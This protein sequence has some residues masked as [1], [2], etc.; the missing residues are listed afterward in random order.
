MILD[1]T[2]AQT[3]SFANPGAATSRFHNVDITNAAGVTFTSSVYVT[4]Q[5]TLVPGSVLNQSGSL[6]SFYT[7]H[8]PVLAEDATYNVVN[9]QVQGDIV[10]TT[11]VV[12][13]QPD[14]HLIINA[15]KSLVVNGQQLR[16]GGN[17]TVTISNTTADGL[18]MTDPADELII[19]GDAV[20]TTVVNHGL[21]N[22]TGNFTAGV[23]RLRGDYT[24]IQS[25]GVGSQT[26]FV[27][28]GTKVI[29]D[30]TGTQTVSFANPGT[31]VSRFHDVGIENTSL[32]SVIFIS[33]VVATGQLI[34]PSNTTS[35]IV[36]NGHAFSVTG[37]D[38]DRLILDNVAFTV[39]G[40]PI[41]RFDHVTFQNYASTTTQFT[42]N[43]TDLNAAFAGL[44]FLVEPTSGKYLV[45][46]D[47]D[48]GIPATVTL[49]NAQPT[50]G[51]AFT[52]ASGGFI[53]NWT[54]QL[55]A[56]DDFDN[57]LED[58]PVIINV[59]DNDMNPDEGILTITGVTQGAGGTVTIDPGD[60][61]ITYTPIFDFHGADTFT[62]TM[63]DG[64]DTDTAG[65]MVTVVPDEEPVITA[66]PSPMDF[67][68]VTVGGHAEQTLYVR[69]E[70]PGHLIVTDI[71]DPFFVVTDTN[72][73]VAPGDSHAVIVT[74]L[75]EIIGP[76][77]DTLR[78]LSNDGQTPELP[79]LVSGF[80]L[81]AGDVNG[82]EDVNIID[83]IALIRI[84]LGQDPAP[85]PEIPLFQRA[86]VNG[87]GNLNVLDLVALINIILDTPQGKPTS[88]V[89]TARIDL[90]ALQVLDSQG[91]VVPLQLQFAGA[92]AGLQLTFTYDPAI[93][94]VGTPEPTGRLDGMRIES[95]DTEGTLRM[96]VYSPNG[97]RIAPGDGVLFHLPVTLQG[98]TDDGGLLFVTEAIVAMSH[99]QPA[100]V[101]LPGQLRVAS[102]P[103]VFALR[104]NRPNPFNPS[105]VIAYE[106]PRQ[107][108]VRIV[109]YNLLGQEVIRLVDESK[110]P[111]R[112]HAIWHG[113]NAQGQAVAS[114]VYL[115]RMTTG[116][117]FT[118][119]RRMTL[120][121]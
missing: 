2:G 50:D 4:D 27:S 75:P 23:L 81:P 25:G 99:G 76:V 15:E 17:L 107:T 106:A 114:G 66:H 102:L 90:G 6:S 68:P 117:G 43:H 84:I 88:T 63:S 12:L 73:T 77:S 71:N 104:L 20:F 1:G 121:K 18:I 14:N 97:R 85:G 119:T 103:A 67:G 35:K 72:F 54:T 41:D 118:Q 26:S 82:D 40:G 86:D 5:L 111:G 109:I 62:Y 69:N 83:V 78:I 79:V 65:V 19:D 60:T 7:T 113:T 94:R 34:S 39:N 64:T 70:G 51:S 96:L 120:L 22:S 36:G 29:F 95:H 9:T 101:I 87:D 56:V 80:G 45:A 32:S 53:V 16:V 49:V 105:T 61:T 44:V 115:Y 8:L 55:Y 59:L 30:G 42:L 28:T 47:T 31:T 38:V 108:H 52:G 110:S 13:P 46:N 116:T 48:G 11:P 93:L 37:L 112:Y 100:P 92:V 91:Q 74:F 10:M 58:I 21:A 89:S 57:T 98:D 3:V 24:Q 33:P